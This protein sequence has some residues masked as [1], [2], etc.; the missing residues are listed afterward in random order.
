MS[1]VALSASTRPPT[2]ACLHAR[3]IRTVVAGAIGVVAILCGKPTRLSAQQQQP[4]TAV[5]SKPAETSPPQK[6]ASGSPISGPRELLDLYGLD[7]SRL[8]SFVDGRPLAA[9]EIE[10]LMRFLYA[11]RRFQ[12]DDIDRWTRRDAPWEAF[13]LAPD[14]HRGEIVPLAGRVVG[15]T[16]ETPL[17]EVVACFDLPRYYRCDVRL[18]EDARP[19]T[20]YTLSVPSA[21]KLDGPLDERIS[22]SAFRPPRS[23]RATSNRS[24]VAIDRGRSSW[25]SA[26]TGIRSHC[27]AT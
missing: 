8:Q 12:L 17:P 2:L 23:R 18:G 9:D 21:W 25:P 16:V 27:W 22:A 3:R 26:W 13:P 14:E 11:V 7:A 4:S 19:A 10:T 6:P 1:H 15:V 24:E 20:I 5:V